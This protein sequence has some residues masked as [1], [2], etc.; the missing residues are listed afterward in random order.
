MDYKE[1]L[2]LNPGDWQIGVRMS[3]AHYSSAMVL[4]NESSFPGAEAE[5][6]LH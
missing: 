1:A 4:Y 5:L 6:K 3:L 2:H